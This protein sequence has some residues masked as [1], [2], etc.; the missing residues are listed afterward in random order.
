M[1]EDLGKGKAAQK[2]PNSGMVRPQKGGK[3]ADLGHLNDIPLK[4]LK[5]LWGG[6]V[7]KEHLLGRENHSTVYREYQNLLPAWPLRSSLMGHVPDPDP[8]PHHE[9]D[10]A[11][12][13]PKILHQLLKAV[14][15]LAHLNKQTSQS[16]AVPKPLNP[17]SQEHHSKGT[18]SDQV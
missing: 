16:Q 11:V 6:Q 8:G 13:I 7:D 2:G 5:A 12:L 4:F 10:V 3:E 17:G 14:Q 15:L 9:V 1:E 18:V